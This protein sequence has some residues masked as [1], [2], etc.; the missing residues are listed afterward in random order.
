MINNLN[1]GIVNGELVKINKSLIDLKNGKNM[2]RYELVLKQT[3]EY[4]GNITEKLA[5]VEYVK[6]DQDDILNSL[7]AGQHVRCDFKIESRAWEK[8]GKTS[9][10]TSAKG[11]GD[12]M[13]ENKPKQLDLSLD[14]ADDDIPF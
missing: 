2:H 6:F 11:I 4:N 3:R 13:I 1:K 12:V 9:Y 8:N 10:F 5:V 7:S 14:Q